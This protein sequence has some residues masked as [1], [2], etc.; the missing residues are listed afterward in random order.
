VLK[1]SVTSECFELCKRREEACVAWSFTPAGCGVSK[2]SSTCTLHRT[3]NPITH[4]DQDG[5]GA[6][7][8]AAS[9]TAAAADGLLPLK[10]KPLKLGTVAPTGWLRNQLLIFANGLSGETASVPA[11]ICPFHPLVCL[12]C[13]RRLHPALWLINTRTRAMLPACAVPQDTLTSSGTMSTSR[14]GSVARMTRAEPVTSAA[15]VSHH[16][17]PLPTHAQSTRFNFVAGL[18]ACLI[19]RMHCLKC[20]RSAPTRK[21]LTHSNHSLFLDISALLSVSLSL[22]WCYSRC[23][24]VERHGAAGGS[25]QRLWGA[26]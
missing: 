13:A 9:G 10:W 12:Q 6:C 23:R 8:T 26:G 14:C 1:A 21:P 4:V 18:A 16:V 24:L 17:P 11:A 19:A 7:V 3:L 15:H 22:S 5:D 20:A 2:T 25:A